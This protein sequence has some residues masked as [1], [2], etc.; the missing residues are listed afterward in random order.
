MSGVVP[1]YAIYAGN[2]A[3]LVRLRFDAQT[4][5]ALLELAWWDWP[6]EKITRHEVEIC[7]ANLAALR[8]AGAE[9]PKG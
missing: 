6:I 4:I 8:R 2:P 9:P 3:R 5:E 1:D 7:G